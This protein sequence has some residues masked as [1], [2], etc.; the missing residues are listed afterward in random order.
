[1]EFAG[2]NQPLKPIIV[3]SPNPSEEKTIVSVNLAAIIVQEGK[4][5][6]LL[7][8]DLRRPCIHRFIGMSNKSSLSNAFL[9]QLTLDQVVQPSEDVK[10]LSVITS[11][12]LPPN[13]AELLGS[14]KMVQVLEELRGMA[15]IVII[16]CPPAMLADAQVL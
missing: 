4:R 16:D 5:V 14:A 3:T 12:S 11:E 7:D 9:R 6:L 1:L 8:S 2:V 15:D 10:G 13:Q